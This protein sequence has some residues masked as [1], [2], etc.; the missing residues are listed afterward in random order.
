MPCGAHSAAQRR[1]QRQPAASA[2]RSLSN[3]PCAFKK[4]APRSRGARR[5]TSAQRRL[6]APRRRAALS[7]T[8]HP[9]P[10]RPPA[11][12]APRLTPCRPHA[13]PCVA[14]ALWRESRRAA[15]AAR[16]SARFRTASAPKF[17][18]APPPPIRIAAD[19]ARR[20]LVSGERA[21]DERAQPTARPT[22]KRRERGP[23]ARRRRA[24]A[25]RAEGAG[26]SP[27]WMAADA[28]RRAPRP[29]RA[30]PAAS[31]GAAAT[32]PAAGHWRRRGRPG[33]V[34]PFPP[35][36]VRR[37]PDEPHRLGICGE[38]RI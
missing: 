12:A 9:R 2:G 10:T 5:R 19:P 13:P 8:G 35:R 27:E 11:R 38:I 26:E 16:A 22:R 24:A 36:H 6:S 3:T 7:A 37:R 1:Q 32:G 25:R 20:A 29:R 28:A 17:R 31:A 4:K 14:R 23:P 18:A 30:P 33:K 21:R 34:E 15:R